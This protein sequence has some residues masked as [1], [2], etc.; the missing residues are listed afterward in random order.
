MRYYRVYTLVSQPIYQLTVD[1]DVFES[2]LLDFLQKIGDHGITEDSEPALNQST[3]Q[4]AA[5]YG[6][7]F[8]ILGSGCQFSETEPKERTLRTRVF[9]RAYIHGIKTDLAD[10]A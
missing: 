8:A 10:L 6:L 5:W 4:D 9:G 1:L 2:R 3:F 7:L